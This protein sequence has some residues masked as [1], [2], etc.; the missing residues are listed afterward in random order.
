MPLDSEEIRC[1]EQCRTLARHLN[2]DEVVLLARLEA[3]PANTSRDQYLKHADGEALVAM[4]RR[5]TNNGTDERHAK[6]GR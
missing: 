5:V 2:P 4:W 1:L 6:R 3:D